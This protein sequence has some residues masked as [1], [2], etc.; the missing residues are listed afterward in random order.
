MKAMYK[1]NY[2]KFKDYI[3][4]YKYGQAI[5]AILNNTATS[6]VYI[7]YPIIL[8]ILFLNKDGR[9]WKTI[10]IPGISFLIIS[11]FRKLI[12]FPRPYEVYDIKPMINKD[13]KG[14]SFPSRHVFSAFVIGGTIFKLWPIPGSMLLGIGG[15]IAVLRV[16]GGVHFPRDVI[17]GAGIGVLFAFIGWKLI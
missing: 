8:I 5:I 13:S 10:L 11:I 3:T 7:S 6:L 9:L 17:F 12:D 16:I 1:K 14:K 2:D 4:S 15:I